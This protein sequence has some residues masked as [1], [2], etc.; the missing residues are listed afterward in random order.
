MPDIFPDLPPEFALGQPDWKGVALDFCGDDPTRFRQLL[1]WQYAMLG[2][3]WALYPEVT[4][5][6]KRENSVSR[7]VGNLYVNRIALVAGGKKMDWE[8]KS[9]PIAALRLISHNWDSFKAWGGKQDAVVEYVNDTS[10]LPFGMIVRNEY[11][12]M[13]N[14]LMAWEKACKT[15]KVSKSYVKVFVQERAVF[16]LK[17][18]DMISKVG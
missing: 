18:G 4:T 6:Y 17:A 9:P 3:M 10:A 13:L 12:N 8:K 11:A 1:I 2:A 15:L 5:W 16:E 7:K 14:R